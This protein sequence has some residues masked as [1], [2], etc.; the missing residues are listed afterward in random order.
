MTAKGFMTGLLGFLSPF[1]M[2][3]QDEPRVRFAVPRGHGQAFKAQWMGGRV[4]PV[5]HTVTRQ[6][7]RAAQR[8]AIKRMMKGVA[9]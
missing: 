4:Q 1:K 7:K 6:Q 2:A 3:G 8:K 9:A 5:I